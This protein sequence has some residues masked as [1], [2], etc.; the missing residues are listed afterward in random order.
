MAVD[1]KPC[2]MCGGKAEADASGWLWDHS[3]WVA[4]TK[5]GTTGPVVD[6]DEYRIQK[7][8]NQLAALAIRKWNRRV[9]T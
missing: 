7:T 5:C 3:H 8:E 4:C 1:I 2:P 6:N 9:A